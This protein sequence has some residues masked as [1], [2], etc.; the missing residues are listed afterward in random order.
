[1]KARVH[2]Y[3]L[4]QNS[5]ELGTDNEHMISD[6][7]FTL[8]VGTQRYPALHALVKQS[9][10][11]TYTDPLEVSAPVDYEGPFDQQAFA[12]GIEAYFRECVGPTASGIHV[13]PGASVVMFNNTF[14]RQ[15]DF[16]IEL[17]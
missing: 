6:V 10:G 16:E 3:R 2:V 12:D 8:E 13:E 17:P 9:A 7:T 11:S 5:Q 14:W 4:I 1:M 15:E